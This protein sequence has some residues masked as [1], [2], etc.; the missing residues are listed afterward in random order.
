MQHTIKKTNF[1]NLLN[2]PFYKTLTSNMEAWAF[3]EDLDKGIEHMLSK[4]VDDTK[5]GASVDLLES[6][7]ALRRDLSRLD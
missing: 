3:I 1:P 5:L 7:R 2:G 6:R 4:F